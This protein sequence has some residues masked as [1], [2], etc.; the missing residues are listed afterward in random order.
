MFDMNTIKVYA[1]WALTVIKFIA[2]LAIL[3]ALIIIR[4]AIGE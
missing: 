1:G 4:E 3:P 2:F